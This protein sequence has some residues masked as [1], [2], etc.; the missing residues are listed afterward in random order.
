[1][2]IRK[3][4]NP[5]E[6]DLSPGLQ[7]ILRRNGMQA[8][9]S[10]NRFGEPELI[11]MGHDSPVLNYKL[12][13]RQVEDLMNWGTNY[14]NKK[15]YNTFTSIVKNDFDMPQGFVTARN[16]SGRVAMGL[17]GYR[18]GVGEYGYRGIPFFRP[19][20]RSGRGWF[21][22]FLG[23]G[24]RYQD[25]WHLRR[26]GDRVF[27]GGPMTPE[28]PD[29]RIKPGE[30]R[31]GTYG[32]Y[33]KGNRQ[34]ASQ[35]VID[36]VVADPKIT[37]LQSEP[38]PTGQAKPLS[39]AITTD[40][41]FT[42][43]KFQDVLAS[44]GIVI[45]AADKSMTIQSS[46]NHRDYKYYLTD[47][48]LRQLTAEHATGQNGVSV[49]ARLEIINNKIMKEF[50]DFEQGVTREM[51]ESKDMIGITMRKDSEAYQKYE[52]P[53]IE[54][55]RL[56]AEQKEIAEQN[57]RYEEARRE[58]M[59]RLN[60]EEARIKQDPNAISGRAIGELLTGKG[61]FNSIDGGRQAVVGEIRVDK[62]RG[63]NYLMS[64]II[65][66]ERVTHGITEKEYNK[67]LALDD[68]H[69]LKF[70]DKKFDEVAIHRGDGRGGDDMYM[71]NG[72]TRNPGNLTGVFIDKEM[73][74]DEFISFAKAADI[75][76]FLATGTGRVNT[77]ETMKVS[78]IQAYSINELLAALTP[79][80]RQ[81][82]GQEKLTDLK[83]K[84]IL[85]TRAGGELMT[86]EIAREQYESFQTLSKDDQLKFLNETFNLQEGLAERVADQKTYISQEQ[87]AIENARSN[88]V[89]GSILQALNEKKGF[90]REGRHGREVEV[91]EIAVEKDPQQEGKYK[92]TAVID[93]KAISHEISQKDFDRFM[94]VDDMQRMKMFSKI[95]NEVDMKTRPGQGVNVGAAILAALVTA[96][97]VAGF[98]DG[99]AHR[100]RPELYESRME[101]PHYYKPGVVHPAEV[102][103]VAFETDMQ[104]EVARSGG[105]GRGI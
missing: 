51:L 50:Q 13:D 85:T 95:F 48:E 18:I 14:H 37:L 43:G 26:I 7:D 82:I 32:F 59:A 65:N 62:T 98:V 20:H 83:D 10:L 56:L 24:P 61:F 68:E 40:I 15:A 103:A 31:S 1:M 79:E 23:W 25:G 2:A 36:Q 44:H 76:T 41:Y 101:G 78:N 92:M 70:F 86:R 39:E 21:G 71:Q 100:P 80:E 9:I 35:E 63:G 49:D 54:Q 16:A 28:R 64:A 88:S 75:G 77:G 90:Y 105:V 6:L 17:H 27:H 42:N 12:T 33:Y 97:N 5:R 102:A 46:A 11:V 104:Q 87:I 3:F 57:K 93:G 73:S 60:R 89:D 47:D 38:R 67:F 96:S 52:T 55:E 45:N 53:Y 99:M 91:G 30:M 29:G 69:R 94:A 81:E 22:D 66:G 58:E 74:R 4:T 34:E 72:Y 8:H 84:Y 19:P